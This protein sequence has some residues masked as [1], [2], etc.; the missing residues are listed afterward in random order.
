MKVVLIGAAVILI[1][2]LIALHYIPQDNEP[3]TELYFTNH[4]SLPSEAEVNSTYDFAFT[5]HNLEYQTMTYQYSIVVDYNDTERVLGVN[6]VT[7]EDN[8]SVSVP[9]KFWIMDDFTRAKVSVVLS[10]NESI[11]FW[12]TKRIV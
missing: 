10:S 7:L 2:F 5:I 1:A 3:L 4:T 11:D 6:N 12:V 8:A 9:E